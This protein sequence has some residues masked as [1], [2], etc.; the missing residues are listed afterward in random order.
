MCGYVWVNTLTLSFPLGRC[1]YSIR[2][3][4]PGHCLIVKLPEPSSPVI[5]FPPQ[6]LRVH[7]KIIQQQRT[8][9][10]MHH[11]RQG[12]WA[13][14]NLEQTLDV[15]KQMKQCDWLKCSLSSCVCT[16]ISSSNNVLPTWCTI[17]DRD[18]ELYGIFSKRLMF[19]SKW[20]SVTGLNVF[21]FRRKGHEIEDWNYEMK[22]MGK[23]VKQYVVCTVFPWIY[24]RGNIYFKRGN[25]LRNNQGRDIIKARNYKF[26]YWDLLN[27]MFDVICDLPNPTSYGLIREEVSRWSKTLLGKMDLPQKPLNA[28]ENL[29]PWSALKALTPFDVVTILLGIWGMNKRCALQQALCYSI[30]HSV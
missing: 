2:L 16:S 27:K 18:C 14:G 26:Q 28:C 25:D 20:N 19:W 30:M 10:S 12:L 29:G 1:T 3:H 11:Q 6:Q 9:H 4:V 23:K 15:L 21:W 5:L 24:P 17:S 22:D 13:V 8:S 7:V